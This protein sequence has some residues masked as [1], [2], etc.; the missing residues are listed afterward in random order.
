MKSCLFQYKNLQ[1]NGYLLYS[2]LLF[3]MNREI[4]IYQLTNKLKLLKSENQRW[5][6]QTSPNI[7]FAS[8]GIICRRITEIEMMKTKTE[9]EILLSFFIIYIY[10]WLSHGSAT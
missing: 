6:Y 8:F 1:H 9:C 10:L 2:N 3:S 4:F 5:H 7:E